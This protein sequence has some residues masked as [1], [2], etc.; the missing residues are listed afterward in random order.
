MRHRDVNK[1][2]RGPA[3][4]RRELPLRPQVAFRT[5]SLKSQKKGHNDYLLI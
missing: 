5:V 2:R 3:K 1:L 4:A